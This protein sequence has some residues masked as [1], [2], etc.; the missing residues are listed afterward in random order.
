MSAA[1]EINNSK[2]R[3]RLGENSAHVPVALDDQRIAEAE[4]SFTGMPGDVNL[5]LRGLLSKLLPMSMGKHERTG[6]AVS[7]ANPA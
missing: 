5:E 3:F 4:A 7:R 2:P 1:Q 6:S